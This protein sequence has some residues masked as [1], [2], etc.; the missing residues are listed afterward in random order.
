MKLTNIEVLKDGRRARGYYA[1]EVDKTLAARDS[2]IAAMK[3][4]L[5]VFAENE[6]TINAA[7]IERDALLKQA[8]GFML[9]IQYLEPPERFISYGGVTPKDLHD[10]I[11][12]V[13]GD[14]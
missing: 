11:K 9:G 10:K 13:I 8:A 3:L 12:Q 2:T 14:E 6:I 7:L 5:S 1:A 4:E